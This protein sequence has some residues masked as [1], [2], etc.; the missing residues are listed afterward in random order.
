MIED[1]D[2]DT[3]GSGSDDESGTKYDDGKGI[4]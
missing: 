2:E 1:D 4:W 3:K